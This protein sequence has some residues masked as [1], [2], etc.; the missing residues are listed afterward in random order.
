MAYLTVAEKIEMIFIYGECGRNVDAAVRLYAARFPE[1]NTP[2]RRS[3]YRTVNDFKENGSVQP[4]KRKRRITATSEHNEIAVLSAVAYNPHVSSRAISRG[5]GISQTSVIQIL[6]R[7]K[8]HPYHISL[9]QELHGDDFQ[10]RVVF[11]Q[12][13]HEQIQIDRNFFLRVLFSDE[14]TFTNH[15]EVNRHNMHYWSVE[16]PRWLRQV[17]HQRPWSVNVWCGIMG[18]KLIGPVFFNGILNGQKYR[19]FLDQE[20]PLL[21]EELSLQE[22]R[23]MWFQH[24]GCPAHFSIGARQILDQIYNDCWIGRGGP[25]HWPARSPD[26]TSPDFFLWGYLKE[27]VYQEEPTTVEN[28]KERIRNACRHIDRQTLLRCH[29]TFKKRIEMCIQV[30]GHHFEHLL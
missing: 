19:Y 26:L 28:M 17:E 14:S 15:G 11:C 20:L 5:S 7:Y 8:F 18:D 13:A 25:V 4:K 23:S 2:S 21:L 22:R 29:E 9:H 12:W 27:K 10:N 16:N 1:K 30:Q 3:F 6:K 24:D